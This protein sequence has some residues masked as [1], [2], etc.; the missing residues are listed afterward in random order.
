MNQMNQINYQNYK[1]FA[2]KSKKNYEPMI[3]ILSDILRENI[4]STSKF[5]SEARIL[6]SFNPQYDHRLFI[7]LQVQYMTVASSEQIV[8]VLTFRKTYVHNK[9]YLF[10][11]IFVLLF[12]FICYWYRFLS[13]IQVLF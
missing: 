3:L 7:E 12:T 4:L 5:L 11:D 10:S 8:F 2:R 9:K 1:C 6:A 13:Y